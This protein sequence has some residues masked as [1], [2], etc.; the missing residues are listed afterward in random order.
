MLDRMLDVACCH[1]TIS[2]PPPDTAWALRGISIALSAITA[3]AVVDATR[4][5]CAHLLLLCTRH[6]RLPECLAFS[7][8]CL[9]RCPAG[10]VP[11]RL[12]HLHVWPA[13]TKTRQLLC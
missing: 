1:W 9:P 13:Y 8:A 10:R 11:P 4:C 5:S 2:P 12:L 6:C 7:F 3:A